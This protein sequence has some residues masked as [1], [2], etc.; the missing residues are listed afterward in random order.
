MLNLSLQESATIE[1]ALKDL[2]AAEDLTGD[3]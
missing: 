3:D 2:L 1:S